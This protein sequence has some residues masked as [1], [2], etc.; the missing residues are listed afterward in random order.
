MTL[1]LIPPSLVALLDA[2]LPC[3][4]PAPLDTA[5]VELFLLVVIVPF[6]TANPLGAAVLGIPTLDVDTLGAGAG[7]LSAGVLGNLPL[8]IL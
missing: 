2:N 3:S 6:L 4:L 7:A 1:P 8:A 5:G